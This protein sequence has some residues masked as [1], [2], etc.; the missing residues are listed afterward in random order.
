LIGPK[1]WLKVVDPPNTM[2]FEAMYVQFLRPLRILV[3]DLSAYPLLQGSCGE[4]KL[5][6]IPIFLW[7][8]FELSTIISDYTAQDIEASYNVSKELDSRVL[9]NLGDGSG[10]RPLGEFVNGYICKSTYSTR[11][12]RV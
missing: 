1:D 12:S 3:F 11:L 4:A 7:Y 2:I 6:L 10:F 9:V 8:Y 5:N